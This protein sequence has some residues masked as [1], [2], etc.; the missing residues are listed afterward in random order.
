[1]LERAE[2]YM[3]VSSLPDVGSDIHKFLTLHMAVSGKIP[4]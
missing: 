2:L 1:M 3:D 4:T